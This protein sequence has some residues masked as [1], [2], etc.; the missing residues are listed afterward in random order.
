MPPQLLTDADSIHLST[1]SSSPERQIFMFQL[2]LLFSL[3]SLHAFVHAD[4]PYPVCSNTT[5]PADNSQ[6]QSYLKTL[7]LSLSSNASLSDFYNVT[8]G[9]GGYTL[10][11]LGFCY[12]YVN[13]DKCKNCIDLASEDIQMH[14][15]NQVEAL[16]YEENCQLRY[17][18]RP[19]LGRL[20]VTGN[21]PFD[22][23]EDVPD[24]DKPRFN[25][26]V[27]ET[28][29][30]LTKQAAFNS[31]SA[32]YAKTAVNFTD[33][34]V[35]YAFVQCSMDLSPQNCSTCLEIAIT[36]TSIASGGSRGARLYSP[37][38]FL[39][40]EFYPFY[41]DAD[42]QNQTIPPESTNSSSKKNWVIASLAIG[43]AI[44]VVP[45]LGFVCSHRARTRGSQVSGEEDQVVEMGDQNNKNF[46]HDSL[47]P[48]DNLNAQ[49]SPFIDLATLYAAT[50]NFS[51]SNK[52]GQ[53]GF[54]PVYKGTLPDGSEVAV[55]R[56]SACSEQGTDEFT[57]EVLFILKLQHKNL[58]RLVGFC[59]EGEEKLLI[60]EYMPNGSLDVFLLDPRKRAQL[61]W[62]RRRSII[63]GIAR[64]MLYLHEDSRLRIIHRDL[65]PSNVLL[66]HHMNPKISDFG[67]AR[68]FGGNDVEANTNKI[69]GT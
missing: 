59:V 47:Q 44:L 20:D 65:K 15:P 38:C 41:D 23:I 53:G 37:S 1:S 8:A 31:S 67:M 55:K 40:Y 16:L 39:R 45:I 49:N 21:L 6:L 10:Y 19:F 4:P 12:E 57:N 22:N 34:E 17:S 58:V 61:N 32:M 51:D 29:Q 33:D 24:A 30:G 43:S 48:G 25:S 14:C 62:N 46:L 69:V 68:I 64:G 26:L 7:L 60:Y 66:D 56:L 27:N 36:N 50:H 3:L 35:I 2:L 5:V 13:G 9:T 42:Q 63:N 54:G 52:L 11:G 28:L 18:D